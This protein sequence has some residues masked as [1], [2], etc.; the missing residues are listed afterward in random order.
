MPQATR[1]KQIPKYRN[2]E[3]PNFGASMFRCSGTCFGVAVLVL[4]VLF[5]NPLYAWFS[6]GDAGMSALPLLKVGVGP[7]ASAMG[8]SF[9]GLADDVSALYWNPAGLGQI[10]YNDFFLS[11]N[12][13]LQGIRTEYFS[14]APRAGPGRLGIGLTYS[15]IT[16]IETWG[17][18]NQ[19]GP[20]LSTWTGALTC[21]YGISVL[22]LFAKPSRIGMETKTGR[23]PKAQKMELYAGGEVK[24]LYDD[25]GRDAPHGLGGG[26]DL[27]LLFRPWPL[28]G[29]GLSVQ[30][31]GR[32]N[33]RPDGGAFDLPLTLRFGAALRSANYNLAADLVWPNDNRPSFHIGGEVTLLQAIIVRAGYQTGPQDISSLGVISGLTLG[34]GF[35]IEGVA[36][37][38]AFAPY[39]QLGN[40]H[41]LALRAF[42]RPP[43]RETI[44]VHVND[45][46][47]WDKG[48]LP[49]DLCLSGIRTGSLRAEHGR[50]D[51]NNLPEGWLYIRAEFPG[52][53]PVYDSIYSYGDR[54]ARFDIRMHRATSATIW[55]MFYDALTGRTIRGRVV[56][57]GDT[58]GQVLVD[59]SSIS[60][61]LR[62]L[63]PGRYR[64]GARSPYDEYAQ[65][66]CTVSVQEDSV[67]I[68]DF[69][70]GR[71]PNWPGLVLDSIEFDRNQAVVRQEEYPRLESV[72]QKLAADPAMAIEVA[73]FTDSLEFNS[74][75]PRYDWDLAQARADSVCK[76][77]VRKFRVPSGR[78]TATPHVSSP[79]RAE[80]GKPAP[81]QPEF[82]GCWNP[83]QVK[84]LVRRR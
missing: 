9:T 76:C 48:P 32:I 69:L 15:G 46:K 17:P 40:T 81:G 63:R 72:A 73:G 64:L 74:R 16:G 24:L 83:P 42:G 30:N 33:Y 7:R 65:E 11:H 31:I 25:L 22:P 21:G 29:V 23:Q 19:P 50:A 10:K 82:I 71:N 38:Y 67:T 12:E 80:M 28:L 84:I 51:V 58:S 52:F 35:R 5:S 54:H 20:T 34:L 26:A 14:M 68:H 53:M 27:G 59:E 55:G 8:G 66:T 56:F 79:R 61:V 77:L 41:R 47:S 13:W 2:T 70:L 1:T 78:L 18:D 60:F 44:S 49:A 37:D 4:A 75:Q 6:S 57:R 45:A 36:L 39:S 62:G 43:D 3:I